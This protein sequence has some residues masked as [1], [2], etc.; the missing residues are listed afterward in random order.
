VNALFQRDRAFLLDGLE[1]IN[2]KPGLSVDNGE[3]HHVGQA[4]APMVL[5][6]LPDSD[7]KTGYWTSG[8]AAEETR[9]AVVNEVVDLLVGDYTLQPMNRALQPKDIAILVRTNTQARD[10]QTALRLAGVPSVL[11]ST[12]SVFAS[13][14]AADLYSLL[15]A[16]AHPG[17]SG[18]LKQALTLDWFDLDGQHCINSALTR[19]S[20]TSGCRGFSAIFM[21]GSRA[22]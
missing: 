22:A 12:E 21:T 1:F 11:N 19:S 8:K 2:V 20:W 17:D 3:L 13:R 7:S 16:V 9:G 10:Y 18:L 15:Q 5:W 6:Q 4:A 14:E